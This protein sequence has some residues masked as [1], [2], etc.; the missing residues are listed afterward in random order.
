MLNFCLVL[1]ENVESDFGNIIFIMVFIEILRR[2]NVRYFNGK[3]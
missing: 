3:Y 2:I 1:S